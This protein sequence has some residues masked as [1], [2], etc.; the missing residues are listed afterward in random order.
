[1]KLRY[2]SKKLNPTKKC[3]YESKPSIQQRNTTKISRSERKTYID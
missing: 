2:E 3:R 1:M